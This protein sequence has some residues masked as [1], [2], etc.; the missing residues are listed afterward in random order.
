MRSLLH[1]RLSDGRAITTQAVLCLRKQEPLWR[2]D[3]VKLSKS[4]RRSIQKYRAWKAWRPIPNPPKPAITFHEPE[5]IRTLS[6]LSR[7]LGKGPLA[8]LQFLVDTQGTPS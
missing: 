3:V 6:D 2:E 4:Q 1:V 8:A 7:G 5:T